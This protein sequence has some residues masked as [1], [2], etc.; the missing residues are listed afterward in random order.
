L[1]FHAVVASQDEH[2]YLIGCPTRDF[3]DHQWTCVDLGSGSYEVSVHSRAIAI[4]GD[5]FARIDIKS[6]KELQDIH[7]EFTVLSILK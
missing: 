7:P 2:D 5:K 4:K 6:G 3:G 1:G